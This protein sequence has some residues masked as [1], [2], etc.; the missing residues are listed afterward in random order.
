MTRIFVIDTSYLTEVYC[1]PGF[2]E[3]RVSK[4]VIERVRRAVGARFHVPVGCLYKLCDHIG[5]VGDG[6]QRRRLA[7]KV[8]SD[9]QTSVDMARPWVIAPAKGLPDL[10]KSVRAFAE[11]A[12]RLQ[13][14]LTNSETAEIATALKR[15]YGHRSSYRVHIWTR[16]RALKAQEPDAEPDPL[17]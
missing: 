11:D 7:T 4:A 9:V 16:N 10:V 5:D 13:L 2:S 3:T 12:G 1:V 8:A 6:N 15:K 17:I 14:N